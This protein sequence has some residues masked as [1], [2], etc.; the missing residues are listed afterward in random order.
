MGEARPAAEVSFPCPF[1]G[2]QCYASTNYKGAPGVIHLLPTCERYDAMDALEF[3]TAANDSDA[4]KLGLA[5]VAEL[6]RLRAEDE[7][8]C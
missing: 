4:G 8:D 3:L 1:C 7:G 5:A 6:A 2:R